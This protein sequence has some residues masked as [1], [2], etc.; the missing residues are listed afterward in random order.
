[1][2]DDLYW[3]RFYISFHS[4]G[5]TLIF[6]RHPPCKRYINDWV[7]SSVSLSIF[8]PSYFTWRVTAWRASQRNCYGIILLLNY[9]T[10]YGLIISHYSYSFWSIYKL[11]SKFKVNIIKISRLVCI[12]VLKLRS[13]IYTTT[14]NLWIITGTCI[15]HVYHHNWIIGYHIIVFI[16]II[17]ILEFLKEIGRISCTFAGT[18]DTNHLGFLKMSIISKW[19]VQF[20]T[21]L[22]YS[23]YI[24]L[25]IDLIYRY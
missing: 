2:N 22:D 9:V 19:Y 20:W 16:I 12:F 15:L 21:K 8:I 24:V 6:S 1:M 23:N 3:V 25:R 17:E 13:F 10:R 5:F 4:T 7:I 18:I 14:T 11:K